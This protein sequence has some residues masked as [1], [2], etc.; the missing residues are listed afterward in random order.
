[1]S[2]LPSLSHDDLDAVAAWTV[3]RAARELARRLGV[4]LGALGIS[5]VEF[6]V[7]AQ[8]AA[9]DG[10]SQA[11]LAR[12][13]G[14]RPQSMTGLVAGLTARDLI[15]RGADPGRGRHSRIGLTDAGRALLAKAWPVVLASNDWFGDD[16]A[17]TQAVIASLRPLMGSAPGGVHELP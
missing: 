6:G 5:P 9:A 8:L 14:V 12:A 10:L 2:V 3:I 7:L 15:G 13:V 11:D 16:P 1:M 4:E 17:G